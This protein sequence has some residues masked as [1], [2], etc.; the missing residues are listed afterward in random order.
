MLPQGYGIWLKTLCVLA[1]TGGRLFQRSM[2]CR[3]F[4]L[5]RTL[6]NDPSV[7]VHLF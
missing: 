5:D 2:F 4:V 3:V 6:A 1:L 7:L